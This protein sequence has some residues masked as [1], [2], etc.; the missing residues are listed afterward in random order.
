M[1]DPVH[2]RRDDDQIQN[3]LQFNRQTP[4][5]MMKERFG[6]KRDKEH[7]QHYW[8][9]AE[10]QDRK[11]KKADGKNHFAKVES[12]GRSHI[13]VEIGVMHIM[14][15]PEERHHVIGPMPPP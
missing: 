14:K 6:L 15:T 8:A 11:R 10:D 5:G 1:M 4:I 3:P 2:A 12:R 9:D 13:E 7:D